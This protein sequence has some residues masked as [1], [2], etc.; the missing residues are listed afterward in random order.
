MKQE[1]MSNDKITPKQQMIIAWA[2]IGY[3]IL[4][5]GVGLTDTGKDVGQIL[6]ISGCLIFFAG[7]GGVIYLR[8]RKQ[9]YESD[10][11]NRMFYELVKKN[12]GRI[13]T[14]EFAMITNQNPATARAFIEAKASQF[15]TVPD[16][17]EDGTIIYIFK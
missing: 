11:L 16:V 7:I 17:D 8:K 12:K 3:G 2:A 6:V 5:G 10:K 4:F 15:A 14:L 9:T 13:T 1:N